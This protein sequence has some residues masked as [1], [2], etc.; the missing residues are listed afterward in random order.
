MTEIRTTFELFKR[1]LSIQIQLF[2][3]GFSIA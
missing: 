1:K 3:N 2:K